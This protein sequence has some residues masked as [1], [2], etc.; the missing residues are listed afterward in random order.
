MAATAST[1]ESLSKHIWFI[2]H[3]ILLKMVAHVQESLMALFYMKIMFCTNI[4]NM[5]T[6]QHS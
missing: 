2:T 6:K 1:V 3:I 5:S 4:H